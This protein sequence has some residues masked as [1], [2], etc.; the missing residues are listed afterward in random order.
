LQRRNFNIIEHRLESRAG[1]DSVE[2]HGVSRRG[3]TIVSWWLGEGRRSYPGATQL[4]IL[5][6]NGGSNG[7]SR[8]AWRYQ[9]QSK[10][11]DRFGLTVTVCH[12]PPGT[13]KWNPIE[14]RL[15]AELSKNMAGE[16]L[17]SYETILNF[18]RTTNTETGLTVSATLLPGDYPTGMKL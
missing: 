7:C 6:D 16:P 12:Y 5:A 10:L 9:L 17:L 13:S 2:Q 4:L 14:H 15:F 3:C 8:R 11:A 1:A 18:I